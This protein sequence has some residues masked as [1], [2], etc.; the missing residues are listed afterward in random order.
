M[1]RD[2]S[3]L[4]ILKFLVAL[5]K[6]ASMVSSKVRH[7]RAAANFCTHYRTRQRFSWGRARSTAP[8]STRTRDKA[9]VGIGGEFTLFCETD[10]R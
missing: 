2:S 9:Q 3:K 4:A 7:S 5:S 10:F 8:L 1:E 6:K